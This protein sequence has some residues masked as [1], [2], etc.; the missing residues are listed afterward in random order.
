M[1]KAGRRWSAALAALA[2]AAFHEDNKA[3]LIELV[4]SA[5][6]RQ[7]W[8]L[9]RILDRDNSQVHAMQHLVARM[10]PGGQGDQQPARCRRPRHTRL[11]RQ[12]RHAVDLFEKL[13]LSAHPGRCASG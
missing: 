5:S 7:L 11:P 2:L 1:L 12:Q 6:A 13:V 9:S 8:H 4:R 3:T 10:W